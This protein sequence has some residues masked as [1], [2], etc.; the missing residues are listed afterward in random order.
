MSDHAEA[1][2]PSEGSRDDLVTAEIVTGPIDVPALID[3]VSG[4]EMG[5]QA[6]FLGTVRASTGGR[7]VL[8]ME[9]EAYAPMALSVMHGIGRELAREIGPCRL[10]IVHRVGRLEIGEISVAIVA[11][12]P[13][14]RVA[15]SVCAEAIE[16]VKT[17]VPI[18]KKEHFEGGAVWV[19]G[20]P[21]AP[22]GERHPHEDEV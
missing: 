3:S 11:A 20:D 17:T 4:P 12:A 21:S 14:R 19:E 7:R 10:A 2:S 1:G 8:F 9:Y 6:L 5:A 15:L 22:K 13:H 18:W 16:R